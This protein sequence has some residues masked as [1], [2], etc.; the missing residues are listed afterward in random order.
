[1]VTHIHLKPK[2]EVKFPDPSST[3]D[4][5]S[6]A[7]LRTCL[8]SGSGYITREEYLKS[9]CKQIAKLLNKGE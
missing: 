4:A 1:M 3:S 6:D 2:A 8:P 7:D 9:R 5:L